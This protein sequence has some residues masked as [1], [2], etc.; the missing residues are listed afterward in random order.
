MASSGTQR[1]F[2][3]G[4]ATLP[5]SEANKLIAFSIS[6]AGGAALAAKSVYHSSTTNGNGTVALGGTTADMQV[7]QLVG[8]GYPTGTTLTAVSSSTAF[9][10]SAPPTA[11]SSAGGQLFINTLQSRGCIIT[12]GSTTVKIATPTAILNT[13]DLYI[14][15]N[16]QTT[17]FFPAGTAVASIVD[18]QTFTVTNAAIGS[19]TNTSIFGAATNRTGTTT[20]GSNS[21][22]ALSLSTTSLN[23]GMP[24]VGTGVPVGATIASIVSGTAITISANA[25]ASGSVTL[26]FGIQPVT[27]LTTLGSSTVSIAT[28][29]LSAGMPVSSSNAG[30]IPAG[31][32]IAT[33]VDANTITLSN[34]V[35]IAI[36]VPFTGTDEYMNFFAQK[37]GGSS[38]YQV[39]AGKTLTIISSAFSASVLYGYGTAAVSLSAPFGVTASRQRSIAAP[40]GAVHYGFS[41]TDYSALSGV[42]TITF[43]ALSYPFIRTNA[44]LSG[45]IYAV[46]V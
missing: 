34:P 41:S 37:S 44:A 13:A 42:S 8:A 7:G 35:N 2:N 14:G 17:T 1:Q 36:S 45:T 27:T 38:P 26:S 32:T 40:T 18:F 46:E 28:A 21:I 3:L 19:S 25:T 9:T 39:P 43:P 4:I 12:A 10:T 24:V 5:I 29:T 11:P 23:V 20:I 30:F 31:T 6:T 33:I 16:V 22:T 15:A